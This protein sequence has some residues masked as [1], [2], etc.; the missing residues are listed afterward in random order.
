MRASVLVLLTSALE[1]LASRGFA[2]GPKHKRFLPHVPVELPVRR[3]VQAQAHV[4]RDVQSPKFFII[5]MVSG[6]VVV[7]SFL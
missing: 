4:K 5:S 1:V 6:V 7:A 3:H 2:A